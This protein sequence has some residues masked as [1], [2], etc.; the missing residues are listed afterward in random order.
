[1]NDFSGYLWSLREYW[2]EE[3]SAFTVEKHIS[4][5]NQLVTKNP[6]ENTRKLRTRYVGSSA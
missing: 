5:L 3:I 6:R 2:R 1:M 4:M